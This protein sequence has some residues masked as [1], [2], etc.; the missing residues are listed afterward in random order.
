MVTSSYI[1][2]TGFVLN[3]IF[4]TFSFNN[5]KILKNISFFLSVIAAWMADTYSLQINMTIPTSKAKCELSW[6][7]F[8][9]T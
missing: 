7:Y 6:S 4:W 2:Q 8:T 5:T 1:P 9:N 3:E